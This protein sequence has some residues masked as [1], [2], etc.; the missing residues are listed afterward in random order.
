MQNTLIYQ[1][2]Q[3]NSMPYLDV[4]FHIERLFT[5]NENTWFEPSNMYN[6]DFDICKLLSELGLIQTMRSPIWV[7]GLFRGVYISF[8][9]SKNLEYKI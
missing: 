5:F 3:R 6:P 2:L 9:Y 8:K 7:N 1:S 4:D